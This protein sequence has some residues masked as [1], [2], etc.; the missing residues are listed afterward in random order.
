MQGA[1]TV[2]LQRAVGASRRD[3]LVQHLTECGL[4]GA[5]AAVLGMVLSF[6]TLAWARALLDTRLQQ[7]GFSLEATSQLN[8]QICITAMLFGVVGA[9]AAGLYPSWLVSRVEPAAFLNRS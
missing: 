7:Y 1:S 8:W 6:L 2:A 4:V 5:V 9:V 3:V